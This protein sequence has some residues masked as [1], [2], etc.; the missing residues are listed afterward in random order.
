MQQKEI[1]RNQRANPARRNSLKPF[2]SENPEEQ[3]LPRD[4]R[5]FVPLISDAATLLFERWS[6][7]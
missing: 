5:D 7:F 4:G 6:P 2:H 3:L 1:C